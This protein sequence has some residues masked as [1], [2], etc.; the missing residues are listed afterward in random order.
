M[1]PGGS[2]RKA[3]PS[4]RFLCQTRPRSD[5]ESLAGGGTSKPDGPP[6]HLP[7]G[8][9]CARHG[10]TC[11]IAAV[12]GREG[13]AQTVRV[14]GTQGRVDRTGVSPRRRVRPR[15]DR[16][17]PR[18]R[19]RCARNPGNRARVPDLQPAT[20]PRAPGQ[21]HPTSPDRLADRAHAAPTPARLRARVCPLPVVA[22]RPGEGPRV[23]GT[24]H[25]TSTPAPAGPS[26]SRGKAPGTTSR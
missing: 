8:R 17:G 18:R 1:V 4:R 5:R 25:R 16:A 6:R 23:R 15:S 12:A 22:D 3:G 10:G 26:E 13:E 19:Q 24:R 7:P 14:D 21:G 11:M 9:S 20:L 2:G